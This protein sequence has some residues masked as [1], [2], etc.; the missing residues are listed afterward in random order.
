[1][2]NFVVV[3]FILWAIGTISSCSKKEVEVRYIYINQPTQTE[4]TP[5]VG[6]TVRMYGEQRTLSKE[7]DIRL[8]NERVERGNEALHNYVQELR[9][10]NDLEKQWKQDRRIERIRA[11]SNSGDTINV[12]V[13]TR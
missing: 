4:T 9:S 1:M 3:L 2:K 6:T 13:R 12:H 8:Y 11:S 7:E 10:D 5:S